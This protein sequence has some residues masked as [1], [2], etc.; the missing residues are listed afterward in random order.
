MILK[1]ET[2]GEIEAIKQYLPEK[3]KVIFE[4]QGDIGV[5]DVLMAKDFKAIII[6]FNV[7]VA[8][9]AEKIA[10]SDGIFFKTYKIIYELLDE[11]K[12][13]VDSFL[14]SPAERFIGRA[15]IMARFDGTVGTIIGVK[16]LE[17]RLAI[18]DRI[19][20]QRG[21]KN[22]GESHIASMKRAKEDIKEASKNTECGIMISP[23]L[24]FVVG[25]MIL[26]RST[27]R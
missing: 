5:S 8:K 23:F 18:K 4:G 27:K 21:E 12:E 10:L 11:L 17:G 13:A 6:G 19:V 3:V 1:T 26:S 2:S 14:T 20:L 15:Q 16:V 7:G 25:D 24:D 9:D 22:L